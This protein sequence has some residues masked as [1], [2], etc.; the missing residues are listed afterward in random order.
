MVSYSL[1][2]QKRISFRLSSRWTFFS[3]KLTR[4]IRIMC[5][6]SL[7]FNFLSKHSS[8]FYFTKYYILIQLHKQALSDISIYSVKGKAGWSWVRTQLGIQV[9][10][11]E[12]LVF[13]FEG[14]ESEVDKFGNKKRMYWRLL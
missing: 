13:C 5:S 8:F 2:I 6:L 7:F 3:V 10:P 11:F 12:D 4:I 1:S 14:S 9:M